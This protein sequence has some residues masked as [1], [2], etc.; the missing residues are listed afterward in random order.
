MYKLH[1]KEVEFNSLP[2]DFGLVFQRP[3][4]GEGEKNKFTTGNL[5]QVIKVS[6][7]SDKS[8]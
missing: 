7:I 3:Q 1:L 6:V 4:Y 8:C 5:S 2:L